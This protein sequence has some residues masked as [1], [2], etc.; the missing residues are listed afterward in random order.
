MIAGWDFPVSPG[1]EGDALHLLMLPPVTGTG[2][3]LALGTLLGIVYGLGGFALLPRAP[4]PARWAIASAVTPL[5]L[6]IAAYGRLE[7][8]AVSLPWA[9]VALGLGALALLAAEWLSPAARESLKSRLALAVYAVAMTAGV[10]LAVTMTLPPQVPDAWR[11][12]WNC[13]RSAGSI[14]ASPRAPSA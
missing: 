10:S 3:Y 7:H 11:W 1:T 14:G 5:L 12:R 4:N 9:V 2:S 6:L 13:R 8:F